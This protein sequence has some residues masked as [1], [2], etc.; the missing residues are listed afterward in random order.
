MAPP[1]SVPKP[2]VVASGL[3]YAWATVILLLSIAAALA[4][5]RG[6]DPVLPALTGALAVASGV[7]AHGLRRARWPWVALGASA[8]WIAF[9]V[10]VRLSVSL[11]GIAVNIAIMGLVLTN[12]RR[13]R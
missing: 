5:V 2:L 10:L 12:L 7:A 1:R 8:A 3:G 6:G 11:P 4:A 13:F 9:L